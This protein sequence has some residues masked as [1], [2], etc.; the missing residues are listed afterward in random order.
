MSSQSIETRERCSP[1][2]AVILSLLAT[3]VGQ[4]YC[5]RW[6]RGIALYSVW[7]L[8][9]AT[10]ALAARL[11]PGPG[12][13]VGLILLPTV[14]V[15]VVY[16][17]ACVDAWR[18]A[19]RPQTRSPQ[20]HSAF[21]GFL[22]LL[23]MSYPFLVLETLRDRSYQ[24]YRMVGESMAPTLTDGDRMLVNKSALRR[25]A[26]PRSPERGAVVAFRSPEDP[27]LTWVKRVVGL[28]GD[29]VQIHGG[30]VQVNQRAIAPAP[31]ELE[32]GSITVP[33]HSMYV[34][35]DDLLRSRDSRHFGTVALADLR[36]VVD[37]VFLPDVD[38]G[39]FGRLR[40]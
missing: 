31:A 3:G 8:V 7:L 29:T 2:L 15:V 25:G 17:G 11:T 6:F 26:L 16:V 40:D 33:P 32:T 39:R 30:Q 1:F 36:G 22:V 14:S 13:L 28:P 24:A 19:Q 5:G 27:S 23:G 34:L 20:L 12:I 4:V 37:Y 38:W 35:G 18:L 10:T 9:F 21:Y